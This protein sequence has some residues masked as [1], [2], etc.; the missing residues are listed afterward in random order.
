MLTAALWTSLRPTQ[1]TKNLFVFAGVL[2]SENLLDPG[3]LLRVCL[4]FALFCLLSSAAY[5]LNDLADLPFDRRHP[6]K[7]KRPLA[8]G[9]LPTSQA[10]IAWLVLCGAGLAGA[11]VLSFPFFRVALAY[12]F[13][14][15]AYTFSLKRVVILDVF[16]VAFGFV[17]RAL[18]GTAVI[19]VAASRW[20]LICALF[21]SLFIALGKRRQELAS[22]EAA[23][24]ARPVL[25]R[26]SPY[27]L[28]QMISVVTA[29]TV[30][31][32]CLYTVSEE[33]VARF[34]TGNLILTVPFVL[35]GVLRYL[36]LIHRE[37]GGE[38]P[39]RLLFADKP[40]LAAVLLWAAAAGAV[41]YL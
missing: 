19:G 16:A 18:A 34:G 27:L 7:S 24:R 11:Y 2:F 26:Y 36:Y 14:Q 5:L 22:G 35:Y 10:K 33:T 8:S 25:A 21:L 30:I 6:A 4:A 1:W 41:I 12:L 37:G 40:L 38:E 39:E 31:A 23:A 20:F 28:D 3:L 32:Y 13:L 17:L 15:T 29:S 9:V